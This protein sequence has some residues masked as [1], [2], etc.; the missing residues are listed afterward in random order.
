M[1][2]PRHPNTEFELILRVAERQGWRVTKA[3]RGYFRMWC[4][5]E[6]KHKKSM[7]IT[8]NKGYRRNLISQLKRETCWRED[9]K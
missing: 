7:H 1:P 9:R 5:C 3:P 4:P 8:P 2:R 6:A